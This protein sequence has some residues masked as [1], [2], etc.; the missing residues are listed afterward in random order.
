FPPP[1]KGVAVDQES[2]LAIPF[3]PQV[4]FFVAHGI[5]TIRSNPNLPLVSTRHTRFA[6]LWNRHELDER[7]AVAGNHHLFTGKGALD[8]PRERGLR[9]VHVDGFGHLRDL[10]S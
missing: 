10:S 3:L 8:K 4:Q 7:L 9:L 5:E 1:K 6:L 2:H